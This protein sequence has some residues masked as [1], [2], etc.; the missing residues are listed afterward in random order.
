MLHILLTAT[1][2]VLQPAPTL[3]RRDLSCSRSALRH[4][5]AQSVFA[6]DGGDSEIDWDKE[7][8][9]VVKPT[10]RFYK[11]LK[12]IEAPQLVK[13]FAETAPPEV[14][15]AVKATIGQLLGNLPPQVA[16]SAIEAKGTSLATLMFSM[17]MTG[18]MFRNAEYRRTL[19]QSLNGTSDDRST[20]ALPPVRG[21]IKVKIA[22]GLETQVDAQS[23]MSELRAEVE[24]LREELALAK[25]QKSGG[26]MALIEYIQKLGPED[27]KELTSTITPDVLDAMSQLISSIL[28]DINVAP[29]MVAKAPL[30]KVRELLITQLVSGYRLREME[31]RD[32]MKNKFWDQ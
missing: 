21:T 27:G 30:A 31:V 8:A 20:A 11:A 25:Q 26:E 23:Y 28:I 3:L 14:Q 12:E 13:E 1:A 16:E 32:E 9:A 15:T 2:L 18:Y 19:Q 22:E 5:C 29:E 7:A 24:G 10:N 4:V 6:N 17:Q